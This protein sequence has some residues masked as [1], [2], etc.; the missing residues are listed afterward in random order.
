MAYVIVN[1]VLGPKILRAS[2]PAP[3][4]VIHPKKDEP[5]YAEAESL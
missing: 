5:G 4:I 2:T 1:R 3:S